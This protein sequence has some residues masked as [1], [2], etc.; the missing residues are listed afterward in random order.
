MPLVTRAE[1]P[2]FR[3]DVKAIL[4]DEHRVVRQPPSRAEYEELCQL[5]ALLWG[6]AGDG[7]QM[8]PL[9]GTVG[10]I[11]HTQRGERL[12]V[13]YLPWGGQLVALFPPRRVPLCRL[14]Y[15]R[16]PAQALEYMVAML[17]VS[18]V[19]EGHFPDL[20]EVGRRLRH[21]DLFPDSYIEQRR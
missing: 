11:L 14:W 1:D 16:Q 17:D 2:L 15:L 5:S 12:E 21:P 8:A 3:A 6:R 13:C 7:D 4:G 10:G 18:D 9:E 19:A 20:G